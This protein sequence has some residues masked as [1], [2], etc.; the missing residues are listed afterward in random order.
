[1]LTARGREAVEKKPAG[2]R[3]KEESDENVRDGLAVHDFCT[4]R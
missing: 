2:E 3:H 1:M 4:M